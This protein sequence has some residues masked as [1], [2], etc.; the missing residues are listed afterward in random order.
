MPRSMCNVAMS[1]RGVEAA[2]GTRVLKSQLEPAID[3]CYVSM[4]FLRVGGT[5]QQVYRSYPFFHK[6]QHQLFYRRV[7][8]RN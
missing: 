8:F 7:Q 4:F 5:Y 2:T 6:R 3:T 1:P